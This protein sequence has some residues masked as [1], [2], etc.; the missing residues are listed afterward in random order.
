MREQQTGI[1]SL[2]RRAVIVVS[3]AL[4][5]GGSILGARWLAGYVDRL[6]GPPAPAVPAGQAVEVVI[7]PG[8]SAQ[9]IADLLT[10]VAV[11]GSRSEF[12]DAAREAGALLSLK[13]GTYELTTG[14]E[15]RMVVTQL[16]AGPVVE[17]YWITVPEGLR[18]EEILSRVA[19][20]SDLSLASLAGA[21]T[22]GQVESTLHSPASV[23]TLESWEGLLFPDTYQ[24]SRDWSAAE[25]LSVLTETMEIRYSELDWDQGRAAELT[26]YERL[27]VASIVE[28]ETRVDADRPLVA[29]VIFNRLEAGMPLQIDSTVLYGVGA[30]GRAPTSDDLEAD[31]AYNTYL[32]PGL[33]P[34][35]ISAPGAASLA[36]VASPADGDYLYFVL[37]DVD[38]SHSFT[39]DYEEFLR[40]KEESKEK[41]LF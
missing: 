11:V 36:A 7:P 23:G 6:G 22:S 13:A 28:A 27:I 38:G 5:V 17:T 30:R 26:P 12:E 10:S 16:V 37:T 14:M 19:A 1:G 39:S 18:A 3:A 9:Q 35:P 33:P 21:L 24:L 15:P 8:A 25:V 2:F 32:Y 31:S 20:Q 41:G 40:W 29:T 4:I 34:T